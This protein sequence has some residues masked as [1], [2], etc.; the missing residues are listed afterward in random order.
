MHEWT[1][2]MADLIPVIEGVKSLHET[3]PWP[4][5]FSVAKYNA[6]RVGDT[7]MS[8]YFCMED[9]V[10]VVAREDGTSNPDSWLAV[11]RLVDGRFVYLNAWYEYI[12]WGDSRVEADAV[13]AQTLED[14]TALGMNPFE[15]A[16]LRLLSRTAHVEAP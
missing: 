3:D 5:I 12:K 14:L 9:V 10:Q 13:I 8:A 15:V 16:T 11:V 1:L 6:R 4:R 7:F 2:A